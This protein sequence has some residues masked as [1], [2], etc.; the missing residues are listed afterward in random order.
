MEISYAL[1]ER[2]LHDVQQQLVMLRRAGMATSLAPFV[3]ALGLAAAIAWPLWAALHPGRELF[4]TLRLFLV[5]LA[6]AAAVVAL[7]EPRLTQF[8][9]Q[10]LEAW[11]VGRLARA[12]ARKSVLGP[13]TVALGE[14]AI[15]RRNA[16]G[17]HHLRAADVRDVLASARLLTI[18]PRGPGPVILLPV[19]AFADE[20]AFAAARARLEALSGA[21]ARAV[22][23]ACGATAPG[24]SARARRWLRPE[25]AVAL[26]LTLAAA[27][28]D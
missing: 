10:R 19:R 22:D 25:L 9:S 11:A 14:D 6:A 5:A 18:R 12:S 26:G 23:L 17:E 28:V 13:V 21:P 4:P 20:A 1:D 15:L 27:G 16:R 2:D 8:R 3:V 24:G 7:L